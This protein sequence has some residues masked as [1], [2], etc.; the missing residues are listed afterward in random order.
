MKNLTQFIC[1]SSVLAAFAL[2]ASAAYSQNFIV[3]EGDAVRTYGANG[4][5]LGTFATSGI[6]S[7]IDVVEGGGSVFVSDYGNNAPLA[8]NR[9]GSYVYKYS[10]SGTY[11]GVVNSASNPNNHGPTGLAFINN[12]IHASNF[13]IA[14]LT[15]S[16]P[17]AGAEDG[18][19]ATP[20]PYLFYTP[21]GFSN[22]HG[23]TSGAPNGFSDIVYYTGNATNGD[24]LL[25]FWQPGFGAGSIFNFGLAT[26][27]G[28]VAAGNNEFYVALSSLDK[29]V[30]LSFDGVNRTQSDFITGIANPIGVEIDNGKLFVSSFTNQTISGYSLIG[31]APLAAAP[32]SSFSTVGSPQ[33]FSVT[34]VPEPSTYAMVGLVGIFGLIAVRR[35]SKVA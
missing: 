10:T 21:P 12:R 31:G 29:V 14:T 4:S 27:R 30:K 33:Y 35:R 7:A 24:A 11:Q 34:A 8:A 28:V 13:N 23:M 25:E 15:S 32:L 19:P 6:T 2:T 1:K 26:I 17:D 5:P 20:S 22:V 9:T 18:D 16:V 3:A